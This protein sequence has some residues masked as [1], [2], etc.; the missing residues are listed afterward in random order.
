MLEG[1][2]F[3][4]SATGL[5]CYFLKKRKIQLII[6][7]FLCITL[8]IIPAI[9]SILLQ[10]IINLIES[11]SD[12]NVTSLPSSMM[13][14]A[15]IYALWWMVVNIF[16]RIYDYLYLKTM[17]YVKGQ[18]LD[19]MYNYT[20]HHNH[21]FFQENLAGHITNR[22]TEASRSFEMALS[23]FGEKILY[24]ASIITF[25]L[26]TM[27]WVN[28]IFAS[29]FL[30]WISF[31]IGISIFFSKT[32]NKYSVNYARRK[33]IV[34]GVIVD[35]IANISAVR[36][37]TSHKF[38][39]QNLEVRIG[40]T[41][42]SEKVMQF[43]MFKLRIVLGISCCVMIFIMIY[44]LAQ[45]RSQLQITIGDCVLVLTLCITVSTEVW[46][47]TQEVGDMFE[48]LGA[49]NQSISLISPYI[50]KDLENAHLLK[51]TQGEIVFNNVTFHYH[52]NNNLFENKS[53]RIKNKQKIGLV[54]FSGSGKS[55]FVNLIIRL[56][57]IDK[58]EILID[59]QDIR[60]VTQ[61]SLRENIS[62]IPQESIL[63]NR[64]I[65]ENIRYGKKDAS[66]E[67]VIEA[68][69]IAH[70]HE[71]I[72]SLPEGYN[73]PCGERGNNLSGGQRQRVI[74]A[75]AVLK[76]API[77]ILDEATSSLDT[78]TEELLDDSLRY[79]MQNKTVIV[80]AHRLSTLLN[81]DRILVFENG[82]IVEDGKHQALLENSKLYKKLW[83]SQVRGLI[84]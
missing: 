66:L 34:A 78:K 82:S 20:Q 84:V 67:E 56:H 65:L 62:I 81:M 10:K 1:F 23:L 47:L 3:S 54:G 35:S 18:I 77:L 57:D 70:I 25:A 69:K 12:E 61:D 36:M 14:L 24:K 17:P 5:F 83:N 46:D 51:V 75:R 9:D 76:N 60:H 55:T 31:F 19:E 21:K 28:Q 48:E 50:I 13:F 71:F 8:G 26:F 63:F 39:R 32:I 64:S 72:I 41:I 44:Y 2:G 45:L 27:Y 4:H 68:A 73:S 16:Y 29:I 33:S 74:I 58:G 6:L 42:D 52:H 40:D 7:A 15:I 22:I 49:F 53:V 38:E 43:F 59:G 11:F 30:I 37:F 79:L 80:I